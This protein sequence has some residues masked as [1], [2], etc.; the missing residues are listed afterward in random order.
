MVPSLALRHETLPENSCFK[1]KGDN[2]GNCET[3]KNN[4]FAFVVV[5]H[6]CLGGRRRKMDRGGDYKKSMA[7]NKHSLCRCKAE[8]SPSSEASGS[9]RAG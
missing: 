9:F 7:E 8:G 5:S 6:G 2:E 3:P 4:E 1:P